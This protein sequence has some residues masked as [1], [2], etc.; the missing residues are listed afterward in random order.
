MLFMFD[1]AYCMILYFNWY[2]VFFILKVM[3]ISVIK[4]LHFALHFIL[5]FFFLFILFFIQSR[6]NEDDTTKENTNLKKS[7]ISKIKTIVVKKKIESSDDE[8]KHKS[9]DSCVTSDDESEIVIVSEQGSS[10]KKDDKSNK[11]VTYNDAKIKLT[12]KYSE[13]VSKKNNFGGTQ[14]SRYTLK[15]YTMKET[16][17]G[18]YYLVEMEFSND[19]QDSFKQLNIWLKETYTHDVLKC[20]ATSD[21]DAKHL[22][23]GFEK[24][25][26]AG[27]LAEV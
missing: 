4:R 24:V 1:T 21:T 23:N 27:E 17:A 25:I 19:D 18:K 13:M 14:G 5:I 10:S 16:S 3:Y 6:F 11:P 15:F 22:F 9:E 2:E 7:K 20:L 12:K 8:T 26:A